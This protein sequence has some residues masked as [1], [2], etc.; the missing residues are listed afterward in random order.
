MRALTCALTVLSLFTVCGTVA[1]QTASELGIP[2]PPPT[3]H[4]APPPLPEELDRRE[5]VASE[6]RSE[7]MGWAVAPSRVADGVRNPVYGTVPDDGI[8]WNGAMFFVGFYVSGVATTLPFAF[9]GCCVDESYS[10]LAFAP[11]AHWAVA[12]GG[13][14]VTLIGGGLFAGLELIAAIIFAAGLGHHHAAL[15]PGEVTLGR[16]GVEVAF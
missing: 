4:A 14:W 3:T 9:A 10:V 11:F 8:M 5:P 2:G 15:R 6:L 16:D 1:A 7:P 13:Q 12:F